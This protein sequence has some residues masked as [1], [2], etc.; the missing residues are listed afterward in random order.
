MPNPA[1]LL[2]KKEESGLTGVVLNDP[3]LDVAQANLVELQAA[4]DAGPVTLP[5]GT[6]WIDGSL[7]VKN[8]IF[9]FGPG[10]SILKQHSAVDF[11]RALSVISQSGLV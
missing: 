4:I 9:D 8:S 1:L 3:S 10:K 7:D 5:I 2:S 11:E 6:L